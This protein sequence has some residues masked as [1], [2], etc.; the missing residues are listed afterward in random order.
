MTYDDYIALSEEDRMVAALK[1]MAN[2]AVVSEPVVVSEDQ[3]FKRAAP[4][5]VHATAKKPTESVKL[6]VGR[7]AKTGR[8]VS[9]KS[10]PQRG[11]KR[12]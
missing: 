7:S 6:A 10:T 12:A 5:G 2:I 4:G 1:L 11:K 3:I 8:F 9:N